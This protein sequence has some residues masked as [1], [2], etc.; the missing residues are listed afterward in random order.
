[1]T[2]LYVAVM[3][4]HVMAYLKMHSKVWAVFE[5]FVLRDEWVH[6]RPGYGQMLL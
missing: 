3:V 4:S 2:F 1:M 5:F 6:D